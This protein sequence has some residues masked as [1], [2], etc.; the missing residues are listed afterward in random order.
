MHRYFWNE[1]HISPNLFAMVH[2]ARLNPHTG[3]FILYNV[4][5]DVIIAACDV[6]S[7]IFF[8]RH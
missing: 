4:P 7:Y 3:V 1:N 5:G 8:S 6:L 2:A